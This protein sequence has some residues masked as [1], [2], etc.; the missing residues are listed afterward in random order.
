V[1]A[2]GVRMT[3]TV[4]MLATLLTLAAACGRAA[5]QEPDR[6]G[7]LLEWRFDGDFRDTSGNNHHGTPTG[8]CAFAPGREGQCLSLDG[9]R[10]FVTSDTTLPTLTDTLAVECWVKPAAEQVQ[11]AGIL[12]NHEGT[13]TGFAIQP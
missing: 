12:G 3:N 1:F 8:N 6:N 10:S 11:Y 13:F 7:L 5:A 9:K 4:L 2:K